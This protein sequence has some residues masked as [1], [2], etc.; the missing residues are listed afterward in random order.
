LAQFSPD[1]IAQRVLNVESIKSQ[2]VKLDS[3]IN[4]QKMIIS[5][6]S[7]LLNLYFF[8]QKYFYKNNSF[9][10]KVFGYVW[11]RTF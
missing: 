10:D 1:E 4:E 2:N 3:I 9:I 11:R 8:I 7:N 6:E 5:G